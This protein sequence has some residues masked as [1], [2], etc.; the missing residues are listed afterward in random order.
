MSKKIFK[1][2]FMQLL[3]GD[4]PLEKGLNACNKTSD[5]DLILFPE[6]WSIGYNPDLMTMESI[7]THDSVFMQAF[8]QKAR[9]LQ[10]AIA[11]TYLGKGLARPT[12]NVAIIDK[13][14]AIIL[15][16]AKVH[17][18]N[19]EDDG[20][21][22]ALES[23]YEFKVSN[24]NGMVN[25]GAMICADREFPE[26][27]QILSKKGAELMITPN[28]CLLHRCPIFGDLRLQQFRARAFETLT[29]VVMANYPAPFYDGHSCAFYPNGQEI[30]MA[31]EE[32]GIFIA[33]FD[34]DVIKDWHE[35]EKWRRGFK[36]KQVYE[37]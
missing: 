23:G 18:C 8:C 12:N 34:L 6:M 3:P 26:S 36:K 10:T 32:E 27:A 29:G 13:T 16:Y 19:F 35:G 21:E 25:I 33:E 28:A 30:L 24:L 22:R 20:M 2:A 15:D 7:L 11:I 14:G 4:N 5:V 31:G 37:K 1:V 9:E 17:I